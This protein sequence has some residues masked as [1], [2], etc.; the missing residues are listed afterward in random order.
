M[1]AAREALIVAVTARGGRHPA[2]AAV[3]EG[4]GDITGAQATSEQGRPAHHQ[5]GRGAVPAREKP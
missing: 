4:V 1:R 5:C 3:V 2:L